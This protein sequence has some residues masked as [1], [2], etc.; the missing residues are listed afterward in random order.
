MSDRSVITIEIQGPEKAALQ[1]AQ[2]ISVLFFSS[3]PCRLR[4]TPGEAE[5]PLLVHADVSRDPGE[6]GYLAPDAA[7][8][9][10]VPLQ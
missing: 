7:E 1:T 3:G 4:R 5:V 2:R 8:E 6:G 10:G 9:A